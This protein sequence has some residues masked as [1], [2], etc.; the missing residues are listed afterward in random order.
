MMSANDILQIV[1]EIHQYSVLLLELKDATTFGISRSSDDK[2]SFFMVHGTL[3]QAER[4]KLFEKIETGELSYSF[5]MLT[6]EQFLREIEGK[7]ANHIWLETAGLERKELAF[8][9]VSELKAFLSMSH[10]H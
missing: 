6:V 9:S 4:R 2:L 1:S 10:K 3:G 7:R 8:L 5:R